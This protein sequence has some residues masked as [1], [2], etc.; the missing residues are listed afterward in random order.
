MF[1]IEMIS[2]IYLYLLFIPVITCVVCIVK[3]KINQKFLLK[4]LKKHN[5]LQ[6]ESFKKYTLIPIELLKYLFKIDVKLDNEE[7]LVLVKKQNIFL[8]KIIVISIFLL[9]FLMIVPFVVLVI[10]GSI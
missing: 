10:L 9:L 8:S 3:S 6:Y 5:I 1:D 4:I 7:A 2:R